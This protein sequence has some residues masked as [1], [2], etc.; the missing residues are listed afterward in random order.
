VA[1]LLKTEPGEYSFDDLRR[2]GRTM[3]EGITNPT[4]VKNLREMKAGDDVIIYHTG[5]ERRAVGTA[6]VMS[7]DATDPKVPVVVIQAQEPLNKPVSLDAIKS[8]KLFRDSPLLKIGRLSV[9]PLT[10][11]QF[12]FLCGEGK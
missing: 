4:A 1:Y 11:A 3:W 6:K 7:V 12:E 2:D 9:V 10:E 8:T 5:S